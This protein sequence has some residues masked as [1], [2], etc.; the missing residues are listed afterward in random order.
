MAI[1]ALHPGKAFVH[2]LSFDTRPAKIEPS[3]GN[4]DPDNTEH[5]EW[6]AT[7]WHLKVLDSRILGSLK[8][9]VTKI[10]IDAASPG[11]EIGTDIR[12]NEYYFKVVQLG[13]DREP[14][15][16]D[17]PAKWG[18]QRMN[19]AGKNY[20]VVHADYVCTIPDDALA[21]LA[22]Q[23]IEGNT[24]SDAEGNGSASQS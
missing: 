10:T 4:P 13:L 18:T 11:Q 8:D 3:E 23:I 15:N 14:E 9:K 16:F 5:D 7:K 20:D 17:S 22:E 1:K 19:I 6:A 12:Q 2:V 21:E 24:L